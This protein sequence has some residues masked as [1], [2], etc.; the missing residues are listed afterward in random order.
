MR[1]AFAQFGVIGDF[2]PNGGN[3]VKEGEDFQTSEE[4]T[5]G[6]S[7]KHDFVIARIL[8]AIGDEIDGA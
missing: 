4:G 3:A 2:L 7:P 5:D 1:Q 8:D 6:K